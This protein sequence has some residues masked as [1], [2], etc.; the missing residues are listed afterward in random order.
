MT[1]AE[2]KA[3][4]DNTT[5]T[6]QQK[7][8][9]IDNL[10]LMNQL[11]LEKELLQQQ[12]KELETKIKQNKMILQQLYARHEQNKPTITNEKHMAKNCMYGGTLGL[13][14][15][16][17]GTGFAMLNPGLWFIAGGTGVMSVFAY[18]TGYSLKKQ[19]RTQLT[20]E[21]EELNTVRQNIADLEYQLTTNREM[22]EL[23]KMDIIEY[24]KS[25]LQQNKKPAF[26]AKQYLEMLQKQPNQNN[27][28]V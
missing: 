24:H 4:L 21:K 8:D 10:P 7:E 5:M 2:Y 15:T 22:Q 13:A 1:Y 16:L 17:I 12:N 20:E 18:L 11:Y 28:E 26:D 14:A 25:H 3:F 27:L 19:I 9:Y 23:N 6:R